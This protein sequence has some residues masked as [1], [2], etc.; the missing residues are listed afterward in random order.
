MYHLHIFGVISYE[1]VNC[2]SCCTG[3][4]NVAPKEQA[5]EFDSNHLCVRWDFGNHAI[6]NQ[7]HSN[8][9]VDDA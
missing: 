5:K 1:G 6:Y 4:F 2:L 7:V 9:F 3:I 8:H